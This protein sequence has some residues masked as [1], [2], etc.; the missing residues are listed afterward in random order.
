MTIKNKIKNQLETC[1]RKVVQ[2]KNVDEDFHSDTDSDFDQFSKSKRK[3]LITKF[4]K[5]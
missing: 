5:K 1:S 3:K 2:V 4:F